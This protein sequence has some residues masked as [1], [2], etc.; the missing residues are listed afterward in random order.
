M[1]YLIAVKDMHTGETEVF[2]FDTKKDRSK[3]IKDVRKLAGDSIQ[4]TTSQIKGG[5]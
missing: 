3:F 1:K 5:L 4:Y 2:Q